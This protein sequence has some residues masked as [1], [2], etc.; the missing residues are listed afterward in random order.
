[1]LLLKTYT[2]TLWLS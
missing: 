1:M 2:I